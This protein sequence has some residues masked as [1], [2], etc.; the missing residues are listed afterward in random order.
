MELEKS[1]RAVADYSLLSNTMA[2]LNS[3]ILALA[4]PDV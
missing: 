1:Q 2:L 3:K 4:K